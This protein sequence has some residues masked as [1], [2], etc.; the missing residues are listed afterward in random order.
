MS[1]LKLGIAAVILIAFMGIGMTAYKYKA[2]AADARAA[3]R[4]AKADLATAI[5]V[6]EA[7]QETIGRMQAQ[8]D[9]NN[10]LTAE[11]AQQLADSNEAL[12]KQ[13]T[14]RTDLKG[15]D[16]QVRSYLDTPVPDALRGLYADKPSVGH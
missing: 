4:Q 11:L 5:D 2:D 9:L 12:L 15:N 16:E 14:D 3:E 6:N 13:A 8:Q 7:N 1:Y 10:R